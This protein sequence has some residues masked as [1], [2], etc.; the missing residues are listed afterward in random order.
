MRHLLGWIGCSLFFLFLFEL[1]SCWS[2]THLAGYSACSLLECVCVCV[3]SFPK[4][5][6]YTQPPQRILSWYVRGILSWVLVFDVY[7][8][9][10]F[11]WDWSSC[12]GRLGY[13][14]VF[15]TSTWINI[16]QSSMSRPS[17]LKRGHTSH[18]LVLLL[19][20]LVPKLA[21]LQRTNVLSRRRLQKMICGGESMCSWTYPWAI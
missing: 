4:L 9:L 11:L 21:D 13:V 10:I 5:F 18:Q 1:P 17:S 7:Y 12:K 16:L 19:L 14:D 2:N 8:H 15:L 6:T 20:S 3:C